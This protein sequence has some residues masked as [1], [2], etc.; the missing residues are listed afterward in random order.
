MKKR[1]I[2]FCF[3][4]YDTIEH[5]KLWE[6]FFEQD[7]IGNHTIY[8]HL[9]SI[10]EK[11]PDWLK[12]ISVDSVKTG[13]C[14]EGLIDA[15]SQMIKEGLKN[16]DN[17]YFV[18]LSGSCVPLYTYPKTYEKIFSSKKSRMNYMK[19]PENVFEGRKDIYNA[20]QWVILNR[21]NARD[22]MKLS[23]KQNRKAMKFIRNM[24]EIYEEAGVVVGDEPAVVKEDNT[25]LGGC[26]DEI[27]PINWFAHLY[28]KNLSKNIK[29][30]ET[31]FTD[32]DFIKD[33]K[34]PVVFNIKTSKRNKA[35]ICKNHIFAR[36]F[37][38]DS[39]NYISLNCDKN[40]KT[41]VKKELVGRLGNQMF[42]YAS[43]IGI[44]KLRGGKA[45]IT[46]NSIEDDLRDPKDDLV[47]VCI[48]PFSRCNTG[49]NDK[50]IEEKGYG[51]YDISRFLKHTDS[52]IVIKTTMDTGFLQSWKYF[53]NCKSEIKTLFKFKDSIYRKAVDIIKGFKN[54]IL[55]G[56]HIR[57]GDLLS[58]DYVRFPPLEY[59]NKAKSYFK[60]MFKNPLFIVCSNDKK[61]V[62]E[63]LKNEDV[64][65]VNETRNASEDMCLLT[66]CNGVIMSIGTFSWWAGYLCELNN[67]NAKVIYYNKE[68]KDKRWDR[69]INKED[70]YPPS[71]ISL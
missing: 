48:G 11:T 60:D 8:S 36:K 32:W 46:K 54:R 62:E 44:A 28:G 9:K 66:M 56:I 64:Y 34:H 25:W 23:D 12:K 15:F 20:H 45:C 71:W 63:N 43:L 31:T 35:R 4:L 61:W 59:F 17:K 53:E 40:S 50:V 57:R 13:W 49:T 3:L 16:R 69:H 21:K 26:P 27:Y 38:K 18:L 5:L 1:S 42:Q 10:T 67:K 39:A 41:T 14:A 33:P 22:Y 29:N 68:F 52:N 47:N 65:I 70:Y 30:E 19:I 2:A 6:E 37:D 24:R 55:I 51:V 7:L 58:L